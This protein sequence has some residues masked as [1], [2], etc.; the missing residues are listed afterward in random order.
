MH[1]SYAPDDP[2]K[3]IFVDAV[4]ELM[5]DKHEIGIFNSAVEL[6]G[7]ESNGYEFLYDFAMAAIG[8]A[9]LD[10]TEEQPANCE[11]D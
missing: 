7:W 3:K 11:A 8:N 4:L 9:N 10:I 1:D 5:G 6:G 2:K